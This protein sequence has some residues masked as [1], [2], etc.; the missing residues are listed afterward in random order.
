MRRFGHAMLFL[1][2]Q[3]FRHLAASS[4]FTRLLE[5]VSREE[6]PAPENGN[7]RSHVSFPDLE[8]SPV[9]PGADAAPIAAP[10]HIRAWRVQWKDGARTV[11]ESLGY[12]SVAGFYLPNAD[13]KPPCPGVLLLPVLYDRF[14]L[15]S[16]TLARYL[17]AQGFA[18]LELRTG[19]SF[20]D[21]VRVTQDGDGPTSED[22][23]IEMIRDARRALDWLCH[24][25]GVDGNRLGIIGISHG[26]M[27]APCVM[28][29]DSRLQA[30]VF[31]MG[32]AHEAMIVARS[33]ER[34]V[35]RFRHRIM[36][37]HGLTDPNDLSRLPQALA[38]RSEPMRYAQAVDPHSV[39]L[40][41]T[42]LDRAV[43]P[44]AQDKL[45]QALGRPRR[46]TLPLG[47]IGFGLAFYYAARRSAEFLRERFDRI[48]ESSPTPL[49][50][51]STG[52][53]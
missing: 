5:S 22:V 35:R 46:I 7:G 20:L 53:M 50:P 37:A 9:R 31:C 6:P 34:S 11:A 2:D 45:W 51:L 18:A 28:A 27:I 30:G 39:L 14:G 42:R 43:V 52:E 10:R 47:H 15:A 25:P 17:A 32:G 1:A 29:A 16:G 19:P 26:A 33:W 49:I 21:R 23:V 8:Y 48:P 4:A 13:E 12:R 38:S 3:A 36:R 40:F 24:Q 44:E 41:K